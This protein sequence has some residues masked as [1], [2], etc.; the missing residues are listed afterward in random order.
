MFLH[1]I[2]KSVIFVK[3]SRGCFT[4]CK[5]TLRIHTFAIH[6]LQEE[7]ALCA[8]DLRKKK[9]D[10]RYEIDRK[11]DIGLLV[12]N[13][14]EICHRWIVNLVWFEV[15]SSGYMYKVFMWFENEHTLLFLKFF[16]LPSSTPRCQISR[17]V[18]IL[19]LRLP[20]KPECFEINNARS[21]IVLLRYLTQRNWR[22]TIV[23]QQIVQSI[24]HRLCTRKCSAQIALAVNAGFK[25]RV[26]LEWKEIEAIEH[27]RSA[28]RL[29]C[30][31]VFHR[32]ITYRLL[33][34]FRLSHFSSPDSRNS[35]VHSQSELR[36]AACVVFSFAYG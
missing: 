16:I 10:T 8:Q 22:I 33:P 20:L 36:F 21:R 2:R 27:A 17:K 6:E 35:R 19:M 32:A 25:A 30:P 18:I 1:L 31:F 24:E 23:T 4:F 26:L 28:H 15:H 34:L 3:V 7:Y 13:C 29:K 5:S 9:S 12:D 11:C 14:F